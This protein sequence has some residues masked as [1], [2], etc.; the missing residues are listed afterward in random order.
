MPWNETAPMN[1][2]VKFIA[3]YVQHEESF[4]A[5]C[6]AAGI[7][8]KTGY[9]WVA[10]YDAGGGAALVDR[11]R[12]RSSHPHAVAIAVVEQVLAARGRSQFG[13]LIRADAENSRSG[14]LTVRDRLRLTDRSTTPHPHAV[15]GRES[16]READHTMAR[17]ASTAEP[18]C[19]HRTQCRT[20]PRRHDRNDAANDF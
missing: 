16:H 19:A 15:D 20:T 13:A 1:E 18:N 4:A 12:P 10:R 7:S 6:E 9:Q 2:R 11:S 17:A 14:I 3:R 5:L 8:R